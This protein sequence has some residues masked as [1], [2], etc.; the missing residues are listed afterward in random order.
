VVKA[1]L[2]RTV[3][4]VTGGPLDRRLNSRTD[5]IRFALGIVQARQAQLLPEPSSLRDAEFKVFSQFGE[6]G[7]ISFLTRRL[8]SPDIFVEVGVS[9]YAESNTRFL[10]MKDNWRGA[11]FNAGTAHVDFLRSSEMAWRYS[12]DAVSAF[13]TRDNINELISATGIEGEIGLLSIDVDGVDYW[14]WEAIDVV[15]PWIVVIEFNSLFGPEH[16]VTVPY[17]AAFT[18]SSA[19]WSWQYSGASLA[20]LHSLARAKGY[21]LIGATSQGVNAFFVRED[22]AGDLWNR[23]PAEAYVRSRVRTARDRNGALTYAGAD[24]ATLLQAM[25]DLH[26]IDVE[27]GQ[28]RTIADIYRL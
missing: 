16:A 1:F 2:R 21:R 3:G 18:A 4:R 8:A 19:H 24:H 9:D 17:D 5:D 26:V 15:R 20:A 12:I 11:I 6:D 7:I 10:A 13:V 23:T 27:T 28:D 25:A 14:L 22:V